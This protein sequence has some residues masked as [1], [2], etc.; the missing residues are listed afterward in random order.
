MGWTISNLAMKIDG[1]VQ[2]LRSQSFNSFWRSQKVGTRDSCITFFNR[3]LFSLIPPLVCKE[4]ASRNSL[5][6]SLKVQRNRIWVGNPL[7]LTRSWTIRTNWISTLSL[8]VELHFFF[9]WYVDLEVVGWYSNLHFNQSFLRSVTAVYTAGQCG[10]EIYTMM[11][12]MFV[13]FLLILPS[14]FARQT[15]VGILG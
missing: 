14:L 15:K 10:D 11:K 5:S 1:L 8:I 6:N 3:W 13:T 12:C 7:P 2:W 4:K 9:F